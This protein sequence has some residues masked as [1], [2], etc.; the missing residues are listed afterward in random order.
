MAVTLT[1]P[2]TP[3]PK[4]SMK[5]LGQVG[6]IRHQLTE[7]YRPGQKEWRD[8]IAD[9]IRRKVTTRYA[10]GVP[11]QVDVTFTLPR[12]EYHYGTGRNAGIVKPRYE[13]EPA[14]NRGTGDVDKM[15]RLLLD[16]LEDGGLLANDAQ[17]VDAHAVKVYVDDPLG[18][19]LPFPGARIR[20][21]ALRHQPPT[22]DE[23]TQP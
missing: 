9:T 8:R 2:G 23:E 11:V 7:D 13:W 16:A 5:C 6:K 4:G 15:L 17:V 19:S 12:P 21:A 14:T 20:T 10:E 18:R 3:K 1:I 22:L